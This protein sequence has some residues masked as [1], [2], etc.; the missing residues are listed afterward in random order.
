M[1]NRDIHKAPL[2]SADTIKSDLTA[3]L[4]AEGDTPPQ[5]LDAANRLQKALDQ[6]RREIGNEA[7]A[8]LEEKT[9]PPR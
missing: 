8:D 9:K 5:L 6:K 1:T 2:T 7:V 3:A 4:A